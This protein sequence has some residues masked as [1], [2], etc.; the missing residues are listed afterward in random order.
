M[1]IF[2]MRSVTCSRWGETCMPSV[3]SDQFAATVVSDRPPL[4]VAVVGTGFGQKVHIPGL[5]AHP[6]TQV[7]A[8]YHRDRSKAEAIA[9]QYQIPYACQTVDEIVSLPEVQGVAISTPPFLHHEMARTA[10]QAGKHVLLEKP[11][12]LSVAEAQDLIQLAEARG[13]QVTMDF[14]FRCVP[15]WQHLAEL[16]AEGYVGQKRLIKLDWLGASR[17]DAA[18]PWNWY[19]RKDQGGGVLGSIG[20]HAFDTLSWLFGPVRALSARLSTSI[21]ARLDPATATSQPVTADDTCAMMLDL[22]DGTPCQVCLSAVTYQG[23][24]H[25][26]E[27]YGDRGTLVI[28]NDNQQDYI[29]GFRLWGSQAGKPLAEIPLPQRLAFPRTYADGRIAPFIGIVDRWVQSIDQGQAIAPTLREGAYSQLLMD[30]AHQS[31]VGQTWV[32]VPAT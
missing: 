2:W 25:W 28:G 18:R 12:A 15:T 9:R 27:V 17:A 16:L 29:H 7:V 30:L 13:C 11:T 22:A 23:R 4:G 1:Q 20:S 6:R 5:E 24:G 3:P 32:N 8:V 21:P 10:L 26:L 31:H 19:A 14:E